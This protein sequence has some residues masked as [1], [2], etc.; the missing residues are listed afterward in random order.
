MPELADSGHLEGTAELLAERLAHARA[1]GDPR[2]QAEAHFWLAVVAR[3]TGRLAD[4]GPHLRQ[5]A[6]LAAY[7]GGRMR[8]IETVEEAGYWCAANGQ[9]DAAV[10]LWAVR[11]T[12][13]QADSI[14]DMP[15]EERARDQPSRDPA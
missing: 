5:A 15:A 9:Y 11:D 12:Q 4:A 13:F 6:E 10:T 7:I 14:P 3:R 2:D 8:L 1:A